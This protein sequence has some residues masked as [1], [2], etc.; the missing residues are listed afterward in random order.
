MAILNGK[1][2][3]QGQN[4]QGKAYFF[5]NLFFF[6]LTFNVE[7]PGIVT[8]SALNRLNSQHSLSM[9]VQEF[10]EVT[11]RPGVAAPGQG[12]RDKKG[13][14]RTSA[15]LWLRINLILLGVPG[16]YPEK[17]QAKGPLEGLPAPNYPCTQ[18]YTEKNPAALVAGHGSSKVGTSPLPEIG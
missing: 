13:V 18:G 17:L 2:L 11:K 8:A 5:Q 7:K 1:G 12:D 14:A 3:S 15:A 10:R 4:R 16:G 9:P 6:L